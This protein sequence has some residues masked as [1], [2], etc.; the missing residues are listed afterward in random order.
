MYYDIVLWCIIYLMFKKGG[1]GEF[2]AMSGQQRV[3][4]KHDTL[5]QSFFKK[6]S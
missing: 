3:L 6:H 5:F 1:R 2:L 4:S